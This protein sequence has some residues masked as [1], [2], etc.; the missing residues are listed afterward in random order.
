MT[1]VGWQFVPPAPREQN[2]FASR[3]ELCKRDLHPHTHPSHLKS[4]RKGCTIRHEEQT[5]GLNQS[6]QAILDPKLTD[7][8]GKLSPIAEPRDSWK[9][10][11]KTSIT[12]VEIYYYSSKMSTYR[13]W[14]NMD[15][16][17]RYI[18]IIWLHDHKLWCKDS[19][20]MIFLYPLNSYALVSLPVPGRS[21]VLLALHQRWLQGHGQG[22]LLQQLTTWASRK[23]RTHHSSS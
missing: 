3:F 1:P 17:D 11:S 6:Y 21:L 20:S 14:I 4:L 19:I 15:K 12:M 18:Y 2:N 7:L 9:T 13:I 10:T 23:S 16:H 5:L 22:L 8:G